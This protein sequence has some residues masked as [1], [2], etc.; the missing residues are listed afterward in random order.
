MNSYARRIGVVLYNDHYSEPYY[1]ICQKLLDDKLMQ[2]AVRYYEPVIYSIQE[3]AEKDPKIASSICYD[4]DTGRFDR[5]RAYHNQ[6]VRSIAH[7]AMD[8]VD[9][10]RDEGVYFRPSYVKV[11]DCVDGRDTDFVTIER[12]GVPFVRHSVDYQ[13][14]YVFAYANSKR[15]ELPIA[16][17]ILMNDFT[18][19]C[20]M[21]G[22]DT[23]EEMAY[24]RLICDHIIVLYDGLEE[25][26]ETCEWISLDNGN[27]VSLAYAD[28]IEGV[29]RGMDTE[30]TKLNPIWPQLI[31]IW[32]TK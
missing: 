10:A 1:D 7:T 30:V 14:E 5:A 17:D 22:L 11:D 20:W 16:L 31:D 4:Q 28:S 3:T 21:Y 27:R 12:H 32:K 15:F 23:W 13:T 25:K 9:V 26:E 24:Q 29:A 2:W 18:S 8:S 6:V 19:I